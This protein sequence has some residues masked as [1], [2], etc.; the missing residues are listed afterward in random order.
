MPP[1]EQ[2][3][4]YRKTS[5]TCILDPSGNVFKGT[6]VWSDNAPA[7]NEDHSKMFVKCSVLPGSTEEVLKC[8]Q[9]EPEEDVG[10]FEI[11]AGEAFNCNAGFDSMSVHDIGLLPRTNIPCV[12]DYLRDRLYKGEIFSTADPLLVALNPF[13]NVGNA[14]DDSILKYRDAA[15]VSKLSPH[16][17]TVARVALENLHQ[18]NKSQ[19]I[20][21]SGESGAGKTEATKQIMRFF[22]AAKSGATDTRIQTAVMAANP[23]LE[24]FGNAK[25]I[26][27][28]N[29]SRFGRFMQLQVAK[30]GGIEYGSVRN[31]LLEK[32]RVLTQTPLER[33]YH[34]FY[35]L[36]KG[37]TP[38]QKKQFKLRGLKDYKFINPVT[39]DAPGID[40]L[41]EWGLVDGAFESMMMS[42]EEKDT[43]YSIVSG[44][45][46][47]GD[48]AIASVEKEGVPDAAEIPESER[49][50]FNEACEL[51]GLDAAKVEEGMT[52]KISMAGGKELRGIW[53]QK[54]ATMLK[55][56]LS[57]AMFDQ[58]FTWIVKK[59]N[60]NIEPPTGFGA[61]MGMLDIFGFEV[62][63]N[64]SL[65]QMFIN[66]T[67]EMLQKNF[68]DV[69]FE[70]ETKLYRSEGISAAD[71]VWTTNAEIITILT[72]GKKSLM[73]ILE[74]QC[75]A[76]GAE[77]KKF[78]TAAFTALKDSPKMIKPKVGGDENFIIDH[79]VG[80]IQYNV[81]NFLFKN[82]DVL[83]PD[84]IECVQASTNPT[85]ADLF[86]GVVIEKGKG[87]KGQLIGSQFLNQLT[88]L[89]ELINSTEPHF[90]RCVKPNEE[91]KPLFFT[92]DKTFIQLR[93]LSIIEALQL[94]NLGFAYRRI[95]SEFNYQFR[96]IDMGAYSDPKK[97]DKAKS[98]A[99]LKAAGMSEGTALGN[100]MVFMK[101]DAQK[102]MVQKQR[103]ALAAW[104]PV[105]TVVE[106][107][108]KKHLL[109]QDY[110]AKRHTPGV[111]LSALVRR[112]IVDK[113]PPPDPA[114]KPAVW[115]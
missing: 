28:N 89:M 44:V 29:S 110:T 54:D 86:A 93:A 88:A 22:A 67:N 111:R 32:S 55:D 84:L 103:E 17:F 108:Y 114:T 113:V 102:A 107:L 18:V 38:E 49:I 45:L 47:I 1:K 37:T 105:V 62:F 87:M 58:T 73:A 77:D 74:D 76:P 96:F 85:V 14:G 41:E 48:V 31:F 7:V 61:F 3:K 83:R 50:K 9:V 30:G 100:T 66:I 72:E 11:K 106:C 19:T 81:T 40:D 39:L 65:E 99:I 57:K 78:L 23:V 10:E 56:S 27:N 21:V 82:K 24:A 68:I 64:N 104:E 43:V 109:Q 115:C 91:K 92:P 35:Q 79:T 46:A 71:L 2:K 20:I 59:L 70:K 94:R 63:E 33:N 13:K 36:L 112:K 101:T 15:E 4:F 26:R 12:L 95:F 69:V 16:N 97:D 75:L 5:D 52:I 51:M 25:T 80:V 6:F 42:K 60:S 53:G 90:V 8:K 98:E 34:I